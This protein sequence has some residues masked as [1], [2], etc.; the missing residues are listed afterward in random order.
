MDEKTSFSSVPQ[1]STLDPGSVPGNHP[2]IT[3]SQAPT[4]AP[5]DSSSDDQTEKEET[6]DDRG[7]VNVARAKEE[8]AE[9]GRTLTRQ[10]SLHRVATGQSRDVEKDGEEKDDF[11]LLSFFKGSKQA[12]DENDFKPKHVSVSELRA[13]FAP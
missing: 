5:S 3:P 4:L 13:H 12:Q 6:N 11:D 7:G 8:F 10:S 1:G 9:L 2:S